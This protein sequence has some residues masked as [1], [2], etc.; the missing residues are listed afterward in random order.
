[1]LEAMQVTVR[2]TR[3]KR[4]ARRQRRDGTLPV[5]LYG[6]GQETVSLTLGAEQFL[7]AVRHG[8]R[9]IELQ[10][11]VNE[12]ALIREIQWDVFG[13]APLHVDLARVSA[14]ERIEVTVPVE[15]R[16]EAPGVKD[17]GV[18]QQPVHE[19]RIE[20]LA[21]AIPE[22]LT[23]GINALTMNGTLSVAHLKLPEGVVVLDEA[24]T[25]LV[26]C[27]EAKDEDLDGTPTGD[28]AEPELIGRKA[29]DDE[30]EE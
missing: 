30:E 8:T 18:V 7:A 13:I 22:K 9:L 10:G 12:T 17:G 6:H 20:C 24:E 1:M 29:S 25:V 15:L 19:V 11:A 14:D 3:G 2:Q 23:L 26:E 28:G 5:V 27:V 4:E 16:G 21:V